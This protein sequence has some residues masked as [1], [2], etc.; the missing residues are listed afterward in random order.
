[1]S[2]A[3]KPE[4]DTATVDPTEPKFGLSDIDGTVTG[5]VD[6]VVVE[7][8]DR[9][10]IV[11]DTESRIDVEEFVDSTDVV[12]AETTDVSAMDG[13]PVVKSVKDIVELA[14]DAVHVLV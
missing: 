7:N 1:M 9:V 5:S 12:D 10:V 2:I 13:L 8:M 4:P 11:D 3:E 14:D 6:V